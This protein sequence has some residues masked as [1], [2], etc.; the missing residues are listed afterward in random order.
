MDN[1][2]EWGI[3]VIAS[4]QTF[5]TPLLDEFFKAVSA[6]GSEYFYFAALPIIITMI[7]RKIGIRIALM[8][9]VSVT[10][11]S[12]L[13]HWIA[14]PRP[15]LLDPSVAVIDEDGYGFPSGHTQQAAMFW[16]LTAIYL[17]K[18]WVSVLAA[19]FVALVGLSR[20]YLGVHYP[21]DVLGSLVI[22]GILLLNYQ[23]IVQYG[24]RWWEP[25]TRY[26]FSALII[27]FA[28]LASIVSPVKDM[29]SG[30]ALGAGLILGLATSP[31]LPMLS[32]SMRKRFVV[33]TV[34]AFVLMVA[35]IGLKLVFP[36]TGESYYA[37]FSFV[38]YFLCGVVISAVPL[39]VE[40]RVTWQ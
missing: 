39:L 2:L 1:V 40:K 34:T 35:Y 13:K 21:T 17:R 3:S 6:I 9:L 7:N 24:R 18:W 30:T 28:V 25:K 22:A 4:I 15:F 8:I 23:L 20:V 10:I 19:F 29:I 16:G 12:L 33:A 27:A 14:E 11:N 26:L 31:H 36:M 38:R 5:R 32:A 37:L